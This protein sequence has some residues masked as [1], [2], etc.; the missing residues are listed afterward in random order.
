VQV[1]DKIHL[2]NTDISGG[3]VLNA[4]N[5]QTENVIS[6][7][8]SE[9]QAQTQGVITKTA[10]KRLSCR[11]KNSSVSIGNFIRAK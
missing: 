1:Y 9:P 7:E 3:E 6:Q 8:E 4:M 2:F 5:A 11:V 10:D